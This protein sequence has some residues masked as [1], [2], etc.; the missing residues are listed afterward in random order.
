MSDVKKSTRFIYLLMI[1]V[2]GFVSSYDNVLNHVTASTLIEEEQNP[3]AT[4][5]IIHWGVFGLI[6]LKSLGT[7][8]SVTIMIVLVYS[9]WRAAII[10]VFIFQVVLFCYLTFYTS[11]NFFSSDVFTVPRLVLDFYT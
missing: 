10:P 11:R 2:C 8:V 4:F 7:L 6:Y 3:V 1:F 5:I 9:R